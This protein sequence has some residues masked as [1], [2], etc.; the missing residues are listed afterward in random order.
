MERIIINLGDCTLNMVHIPGDGK[1]PGFYVSETPVT[2]QQY[3]AMGPKNDPDWASWIEYYESIGNREYEDF[4]VASA[5]TV[6]NVIDFINNIRQ[7]VFY[8]LPSR[9]QWL[10]LAENYYERVKWCF[11]S[12]YC[13]IC[14]YDAICWEMTRDNSFGIYCLLGFDRDLEGNRIIKGNNF[15]MSRKR[16]NIAF[17]LVCSEIEL[18]TNNNN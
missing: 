15:A 3:K 18:Q 2:M 7:P 6:E 13:G 1:I 8:C 4:T 9:E 16:D 11:E 17:R 10:H 12:R 5:L 14:D